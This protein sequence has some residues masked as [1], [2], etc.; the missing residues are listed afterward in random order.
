MSAIAAP[1]KAT[2]APIAATK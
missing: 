1:E 2:E